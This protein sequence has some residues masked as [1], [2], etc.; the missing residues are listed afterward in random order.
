MSR[1]YGLVGGHAGGS[2]QHGKQHRKQGKGPRGGPSVERGVAVAHT[3]K[4]QWSWSVRD[5]MGSGVG[6]EAGRQVSCPQVDSGNP[7]KDVVSDSK[8][9]GV[10]SEV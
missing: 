2:A 7:G 10:T 4:S 8:G 5:R 3:Q 6:R 9:G 1:T